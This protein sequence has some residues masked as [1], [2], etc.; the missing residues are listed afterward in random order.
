MSPASNQTPRARLAARTLLALAFAGLSAGAIAQSQSNAGN[1]PPAG[2]SRPP[3]EAMTACK[4]AKSGDSCSFT[5]QS[6]A[7]SGTCQAPE[8][9]PLACR[10]QN[11]PAA[12]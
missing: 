6:G 12:K 3:A 5:G 7:I 4:T 8:G 11:A 1:G 9:R 2:Q 10:P